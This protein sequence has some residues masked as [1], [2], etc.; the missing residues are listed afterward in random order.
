MLP[1]VHQAAPAQ[2]TPQGQAVAAGGDSG[3]TE[4]RRGRWVKQERGGSPLLCRGVTGALLGCPVRGDPN[5]VGGRTRS[6]GCCPLIP[7]PNEVR[8]V[9]PFPPAL[10]WGGGQGGEEA[11]GGEGRCRGKERAE[12]LQKKIFWGKGGWRGL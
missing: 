4:N 12:A 2:R 3:G 10:R 11:A 8:G 9:A 1:P 5:R 7:I 6:P